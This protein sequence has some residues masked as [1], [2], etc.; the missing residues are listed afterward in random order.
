MSRASNFIDR[1]KN[2]KK[3]HIILGLM[4]NPIIIHINSKVFASIITNTF[5]LLLLA[6]V[7][8]FLF[9]F[10]ARLFGVV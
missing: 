8:C 4:V 3:S 5:L 1:I 9:H 10:H 2:D 6:V 7:F